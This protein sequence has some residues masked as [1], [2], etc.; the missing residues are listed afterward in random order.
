MIQEKGL[1]NQIYCWWYILQNQT[2]LL[3]SIF[4]TRLVD[5]LPQNE[6]EFGA[7]T[8]HGGDDPSQHL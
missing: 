7:C 6:G 4:Q 5:F 8:I 1:F 3:V 2:N